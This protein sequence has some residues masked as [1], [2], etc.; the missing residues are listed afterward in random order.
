MR[1]A[2]HAKFLSEKQLNGMGY[3]AYNLLKGLSEIDKENEYVLYSNAP[4]FHKIRAENFREKILNF[5]K[6]WTYL[7][8]PLEFI[9]G[10]YEIVF[11]P[12]DKLPFFVKAR[13][14]ITIHDVPSLKEFLTNPIPLSAKINF[15][16][17]FT[18][19]IKKADRII[20]NSETTKK[21]IIEKCK[22][23]PEKITVTP[24]GYDK[25]L[26]RPCLDQNLIKKVKEKYGIKGNYIINT[27]S[28]LWY[29]KNLN[30][31]IRAFSACKSKVGIDH[32]LVITGKKGKAYEEIVNLIH[33]LKL[34]KDVILSGFIPTD[35]MPVLLSGADA[36]VFPS[37]YEGFGL[38]LVEAMACGC[39]VITSNVSAMPE[40]VGDAEVLVDPY[41]EGEIAYGMERVLTDAELRKQMRN[42]GFE[43]AKMFSWDTTARKTLKVF[44]SLK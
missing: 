19:A 44:E 17:A 11:I 13:S 29:R 3:Y 12:R 26:Y 14:V 34:E 43:R 33:F 21:D 40:V 7:R 31:L 35:D 27:S 28:V 38:P 39:P 18:Y 8:W 20:A 10:K 9:N 15:F 6:G 1:I 41:S 42:R 23:K 4:I 36:L 30:R 2:V 25:A 16:L 5:P 37:L 32:Q 24:L 22:V